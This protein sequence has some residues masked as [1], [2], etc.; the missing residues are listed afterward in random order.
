MGNSQKIHSLLLSKGWNLATGKGKGITYTKKGISLHIHKPH[1][2]NKVH[3]YLIR[4]IRD[5]LEAI[6]EAP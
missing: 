1:P 2:S 4:L 3:Q 5:F 6:G